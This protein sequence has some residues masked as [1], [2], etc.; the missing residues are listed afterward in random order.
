[1]DT[2]ESISAI[3]VYPDWVYTWFPWLA[4]GIDCVAIV[5]P[6]V[7][8]AS[9]A[10]TNGGVI[11]LALFGATFAANATRCRLGRPVT[12]MIERF[13]PTRLVRP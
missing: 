8:L 5:V 4:R 2:I 6:G 12:L 13:I 1:M 3:H 9:L 11:V 7:A 10:K